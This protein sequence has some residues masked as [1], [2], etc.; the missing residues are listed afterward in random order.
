[1]EINYYIEHVRHLGLFFFF[2][3]NANMYVTANKYVYLIRN[4]YT[5]KHGLK[6][7]NEGVSLNEFTQASLP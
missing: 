6:K 4:N 3:S 2:L 1:M 7:N 5:Q